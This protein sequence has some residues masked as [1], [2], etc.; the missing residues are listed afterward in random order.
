ME[1]SFPFSSNIIVYLLD[2]V[3]TCSKGK[4]SALVLTDL[5]YHLKGELEGRGMAPGSF[6]DLSTFL[7]CL[8][9]FKKND[10]K[11]MIAFLPPDGTSYLFNSKYIR[12]RINLKCWEY[13][14]LET[15]KEA[16]GNML[17]H[18]S[19]ANNMVFCM[20]SKHSALK[21]LNSVLSVSLVGFLSD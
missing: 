18:I 13:S 11:S 15:S 7:L 6:K 16:I 3:P 2:H 10:H 21:A 4:E 20:D 14:K 12:R 9:I 1:L 8:D 5:Y 17:M 19:N